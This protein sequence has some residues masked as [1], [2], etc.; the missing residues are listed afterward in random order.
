MRRRQSAKL[1][2]C[3]AKLLFLDRFENVV[4]AVDLESIERITV[5][6]GRENDRAFDVYLLENL[7]SLSVRQ[8][9]IH[10]NQIGQGIVLYPADRFDDRLDHG[11]DTDR[12]V[13]LEQ[14]GFQV[15][16]SRR[17]VFDN[18]DIHAFS[19]LSV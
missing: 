4:D 5:V 12:R 2:E 7:E 8:M 11:L 13:D 10:K 9:N 17:L 16:G 3:P 15:G 1:V 14:Q 19:V 6:R 18:Q